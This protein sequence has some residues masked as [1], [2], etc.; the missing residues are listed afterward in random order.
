MATGKKGASVQI[1]RVERRIMALNMRRAGASYREIATTLR[2]GLKTAERDVRHALAALAAEQRAGAEALR[3]LE[4]ARLD[5]LQVAFWRKAVAGDVEAAKVVLRIFERRARLL[6]LDVQPGATLE[7]NVAVI[8]RWS[9]GNRTIDVP[10]HDGDYPA[11][12]LPEPAAGGDAPGPLSYR[13]RWE[14][15]GQEPP[16]GDAEHQTLA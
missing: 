7:T 2:C 16:G 9:D 10:P 13:V 6:G 11:P 8:L 15:L 4:A 1:N 14:T 5:A 12:A 3:A